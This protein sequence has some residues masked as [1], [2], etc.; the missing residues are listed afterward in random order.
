[1]N[2][3]IHLSNCQVIIKTD[4][5]TYMPYEHQYSKKYIN[6]FIN[7][8]DDIIII[9]NQTN[10]NTILSAY[11]LSINKVNNEK[12]YIQKCNQIDLFN[13]TKTYKTNITLEN[14]KYFMIHLCDKCLRY[15]F[16]H[17]IF[18]LFPILYYYK[19]HHYD[20][21]LCLSKRLYTSIIRD[22]IQILQ[23][24]EDKI[25]ILED[26][27]LYFINDIYTY[28]IV[29]NEWNFMPVKWLVNYVKYSKTILCENK[30]LY[31]PYISK[32]I[33]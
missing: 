20:M 14:K 12:Y 28:Q 25:T 17:N 11:W 23:I 22:I 13:L 10:I 24:A 16:G 4:I 1:M 3:L 9:E 29:N 19:V 21:Q 32:N 31:I 15:S 7:L 30:I 8:T 33:Y 27:I 26:E 2:N 6:P 5:I 18:N